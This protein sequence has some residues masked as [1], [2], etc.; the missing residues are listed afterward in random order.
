MKYTP[1]GDDICKEIV[2]ELIDNVVENRSDVKIKCNEDGV[3]ETFE[4]KRKS[5][6]AVEIDD[7]ALRNIMIIQ[8]KEY[9]HKIA[10][11]ENVYKILGEGE[12]EEGA[13]AT[14][15]KHALDLYM[16]QG[17]IL[18]Y[19]DVDLKPWQRALMEEVNSPTDR[20]I[21]WVIGRRGNEGKT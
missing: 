20:H 17:N 12:A 21:I 5:H 4:M 6:E 8:T 7:E 10:L 18:N 11:G 3:Q 14:D 19:M 9:K 2:L 1:K 16:K 13:L 15:L